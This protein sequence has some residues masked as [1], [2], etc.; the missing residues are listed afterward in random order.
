MCDSTSVP[1]SALGALSLGAGVGGGVL[2]SVGAYQ[3]S[4]ATAT[5]YSMQAAVASNNAAINDMRAV[6]AGKR[7][8]TAVANSGLQTR[9]LAGQQEALMAAHGVSL[10]YG[11]ALNILSDTAFM[12]GRDADL[13][14]VNAEKEAWGY[15]VAASNERG[16]SELLA[17][18]AGVE[19]PLRSAFTTALTSTGV[20][21]GSWYNARKAGVAV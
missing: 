8:Q 21:A 14:A 1:T 18:R 5:A 16:N 9:Q 10:D 20:V 15:R 13:I 3:K 17:Q 19:S 2:N 12:G 11:S 7:G 4:K 6:D